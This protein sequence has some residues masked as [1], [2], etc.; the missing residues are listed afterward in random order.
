MVL[1]NSEGQ[2]L[3]KGQ[4]AKC[5]AERTVASTAWAHP[6]LLEQGKQGRPKGRS[7]GQPGVQITT[8]V[9]S[10]KTGLRS[11]WEV[12][13]LVRIKFSES[14]EHQ[15]QHGDC[16]ESLLLPNLSFIDRK[17]TLVSSII[18]LIPFSRN[19]LFRFSLSLMYA[20]ET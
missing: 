5:N 15:T 16:Q 11:S 19:K 2:L 10:D 7:Q 18:C 14:N 8:E 9:C 20:F 17:T 13:P 1:G 6:T 3:P 12:S 4:G